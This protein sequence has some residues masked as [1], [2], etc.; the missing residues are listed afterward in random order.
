MIDIV[1]HE[2]YRGKLEHY[3]VGFCVFGIDGT[4][5]TPPGAPDIIQ[6]FGVLATRKEWKEIIM[7]YETLNHITIAGSK[8][9]FK[10]SEQ[11]ML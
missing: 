6:E 5:A 3:P 8:A 10:D 2:F 11:S 4:S 1:V 9:P 7:V